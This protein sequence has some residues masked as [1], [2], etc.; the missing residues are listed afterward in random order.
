MFP[1]WALYESP[2]IVK[3]GLDSDMG[4]CKF[5]LVLYPQDLGCY[6]SIFKWAVRD[7]IRQVRRMIVILQH[8]QRKAV[9][10]ASLSILSQCAGQ[11]G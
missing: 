7:D 2:S 4:L 8:Q 3:L 9:L 6:E 10:L 1:H 11:G 5:F